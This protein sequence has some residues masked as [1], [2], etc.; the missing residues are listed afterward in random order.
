[1]LFMKASLLAHVSAESESHKD[2]VLVS[3]DSSNHINGKPSERIRGG[4]GE[5]R[6]E[7]NMFY[8]WGFYFHKFFSCKS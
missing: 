5:Q 6:L 8:V 7:M 1:M 4:S 2:L 3:G